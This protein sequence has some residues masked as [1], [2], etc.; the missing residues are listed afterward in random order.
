MCGIA[1]IFRYG[2]HCETVDMAKWLTVANRVLWKRGPDGSGTWVSEDGTAGLTHRRLAII[3]LSSSGAQPMAILEGRLRIVFNGE[4]YN[5]KEL[6]QD[7]QRQ[8]CRFCSTSDTEVLL[9]LY[10]QEGTDMVRHLRGMYAF[11]IWDENK[12]GLFLA[13]DPHGIKP[14]YYIDNGHTIRVASQVKAL[15]AAGGADTSPEP[16]GHVG[17]FLWGY[18]PEPYT[19][20]KE[21]HPLPAGSTLWIKRGDAKPEPKFFYRLTDQLQRA[22]Q[23]S[24]PSSEEETGER[25]KAALEDSVRHHMVSDVPV[26]LFL[27]A[28][29][30]STSIAALAARCSLEPLRT[31]TLGFEKYRGALNDETLLAGSVAEKLS[32]QHETRWMHREEF[33]AELDHIFASMDQPSVDGVNTY[34]VSKAAREI[35]LKVALSGLGGDELLG[36]YPSFAQVPKMVRFTRP[37]SFF[38]KTFRVVTAPVLRHFISPKVAGIL[39]YGGTMGGAYL[40]RRGLYMP[41]ELSSILDPDMVR[42]GWQTLDSIINLNRIVAQLS[43]DHHRVSALE[44]IFYMRNMLLRDTDWA[45]MAHS[46]EVRVPLV[47]V[48]LIEAVAPLLAGPLRPDKKSMARAAWNA[49]PRALLQRPKTGFSFPIRDWLPSDM[50]TG[51]H[52]LRGWARVVYR[53]VQQFGFSEHQCEHYENFR[54][55]I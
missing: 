16:A 28:G 34:F 43:C 20:Y 7:L 13:R 54:D 1:A 9:H 44:S 22:A 49:V 27:S 32:C 29:L 4:I 15:L 40:L 2:G 26:G 31:F 35:G 46:L 47:D 52:G 36:G 23:D 55:A 41:W 21:I 37:F 38:G 18:V 45:S 39:E 3:D 51:E 25:L 48:N 6:R 17:F 24:T 42:Q 8:G 10:S 11:A 33:T 12:Q 5:Y 30:D 14:L 53:E 19:L 50:Q